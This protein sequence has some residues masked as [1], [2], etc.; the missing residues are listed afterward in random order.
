MPWCPKCKDEYV[1]GV[2][3]CADCGVELV[4]ELPSEETM[5]DVPAVLCEIKSREV[6]EKLTAYLNYSGIQTASLM[7]TENDDNGALV[8]VTAAFEGER[9][10]EILAGIRKENDTEELDIE[11]LVPELEEKLK[12]L[13]SEEASQMFS[14]LRTEASSVYVKKKDKY[15]DLIFS[16]ISFLVFGVIGF[17]VVV[18]NLLDIVSWLNQFSAIIMTIVFILFLVAGITS[19]I[20]ARKLQ[21]IVKEEEEVTEQVTEWIDENITDER[22]AGLMDPDESQEKNYFNVHGQLCSIVAEQFPFFSREYIDQ[23]MDDRYNQYCE[24]NETESTE[25][26]SEN[27]EEEQE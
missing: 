6:G 1:E 20:R 2:T 10:K 18:L 25:E 7:T 4:D 9:A 8:V 11:S 19:I 16:G 5:D 24:D 17:V 27:G 21:G 15:S 3:I 23:L 14:E 22:I 26:E 13:E 12:E